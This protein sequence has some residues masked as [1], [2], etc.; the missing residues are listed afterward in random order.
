MNAGAPCAFMAESE[1]E[2]KPGI[3]LAALL[4]GRGGNPDNKSC[5][6][7]AANAPAAPGAAGEVVFNAG[8]KLP[9][10]SL[11]SSPGPKS[12]EGT[13]NNSS[14]DTPGRDWQPCR[15]HGARASEIAAV[16]AKFLYSLKILTHALLPVSL[17]AGVSRALLYILLPSPCAG[18]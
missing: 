1:Q 13:L 3:R 9:V 12:L 4:P 11:T 8:G 15:F 18:A 10:V 6:R 16:A 7:S 5:K 14:A 17:A 2:Y